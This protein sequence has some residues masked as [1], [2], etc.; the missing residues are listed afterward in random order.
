M[1]RMYSANIIY[2]NTIIMFNRRSKE[3]VTSMLEVSC[4][5]GK[6]SKGNKKKT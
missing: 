4:F 3:N 2:K 1:G 5:Q 6:F